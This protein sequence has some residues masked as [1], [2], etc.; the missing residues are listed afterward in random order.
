MFSKLYQ[1]FAGKT[2]LEIDIKDVADFL[3]KCGCQDSIIFVPEQMD[4]G[5]I[6]GLYVQ[7]TTHP[8]VYTAPELVTLVIYP[9]NAPVD[10]Q[11]VVCCKELIHVCD[12][13]AAK[14]NSPEEVDALVEK[15]LGP[16]STEDYGLADL[17]ASV[18]KIAFYQALAILFPEA[19]RAVA[20]QRIADKAATPEDI[21]AWAGLPLS[22]VNLVL[23]DQWGEVLEVIRTM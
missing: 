23:S 5:E 10:M 21:A 12:G 16:L 14:T 7:Y 20:L 22:M 9:G 1:E 13:N 4:P 8:G 3:V 19:A 2:A 6:R 11:R 17:M 15:L 18:D